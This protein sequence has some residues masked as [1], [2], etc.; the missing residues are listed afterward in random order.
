MAAKPERTILIRNVTAITMTDAAPSPVTGVLIRGGRI[1]S[2]VP[3]G[4]PLPKADEIIDGVGGF[5]IPGLIDAHVHYPYG[6]LAKPANYL[7]YGVTT[8]FSLGTPE[9]EVPAV[10]AA[11]AEIS[12]GRQARPH[13]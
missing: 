13:S 11:R 1:A 6:G 4:S 5:L 3:A 8:V 12:R 7:R 9:P 10:L 2:L